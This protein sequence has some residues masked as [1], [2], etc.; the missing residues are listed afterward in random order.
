MKNGIYI[1]VSLSFLTL[2]ASCAKKSFDAPKTAGETATASGEANPSINDLPLIDNRPAEQV[3]CQ[4]GP[5]VVA[6]ANKDDF[7]S[8]FKLVCQG[9][10]TT[11]LFKDLI[12]NAYKGGEPVPRVYRMDVGD[13]YI[14][15]LGL[16]YAIK[17]TLPNPSLFADLKPHD[18]FANGIKE[19]NSELV[20]KV[21]S[22]ENFP[23]KRAVEKVILNYDLKN[24]NGAGIFDRRRTEFN[25]YLLVEGNRDITV[26][27]EHLLDA[28]KNRTYHTARGLT[29]G[30]KGEEGQTYLVFF[31]E[32]V[33]KNQIDP[34]RMKQ[35]MTDLNRGVMKLL[36]NLTNK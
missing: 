4:D 25:T 6:A 15:T 27:T 8:L 32:L 30:V 36:Y 14:T 35:T 11:P 24:A 33:I 5:K 26:S 16:V 1:A 10:A 20:I 21:E 28:E 34:P 23:G 31:T 2:T 3:L 22:R 17:A 18:I 13:L 29:I 19:A 7:S 9:N 12:A